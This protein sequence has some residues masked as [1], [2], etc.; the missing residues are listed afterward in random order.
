MYAIELAIEKQSIVACYS[1]VMQ[2]SREH[3]QYWRFNVDKNVF[4]S[5]ARRIEIRSLRD[6]GHGFVLQ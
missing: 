2:I 3:V 5:S 4:R 1:V 6:A